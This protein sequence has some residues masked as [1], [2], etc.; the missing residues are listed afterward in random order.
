[1]IRVCVSIGN[2]LNRL[3]SFPTRFIYGCTRRKTVIMLLL[4]YYSSGRDNEIIVAVNC[5]NEYSWRSELCE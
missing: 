5:R 2:E 1:M 4:C 3:L